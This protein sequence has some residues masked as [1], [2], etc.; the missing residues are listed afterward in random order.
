MAGCVVVAAL[1]ASCGDED[2][3]NNPRPPI[4]LELTGVIRDDAVRVSPSSIGAGPVL[5]TVSNQ[6]GNVHT[7]ILEGDSL[8]GQ[9]GPVAPGG[10]AT[11]QQTLTP[12]SYEVRAGTE[13]ALRKEIAPAVLE[14]GEER[15]SSNN[16]LLLP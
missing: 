9:E 4:P 13:K 7:V 16:D 11:I 1:L 5:I 10:T 8:T 2:F 3:A 15:P 6:T 14:I 12:G